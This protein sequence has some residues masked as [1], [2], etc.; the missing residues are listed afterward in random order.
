M[1][2]SSRVTPRPRARKA[3]HRD[4]LQRTRRT[5]FLHLR[6]LLTFWQL[7]TLEIDSRVMSR[8]VPIAH[9]PLV[10][11]A[12]FISFGSVVPEHAAAADQGKG[13]ECAPLDDP[14]ARLACFDAAFP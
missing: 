14:A 4:A 9:F 6:R 12:V 1:A 10:L 5:L 7:I 3:S 8:L 11:A 13:A 2:Y